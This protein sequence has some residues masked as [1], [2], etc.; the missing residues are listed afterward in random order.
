[1]PA[2]RLSMRKIKEVIRLKF[3]AGLGN[4]QIARSCGVNH[5][6]VADYLRRAK[7]AGLASWPL[8]V[9]LDETSLEVRLFPPGITRSN[10]PRSAPDWPHIHEELHGHKHVTLQLLW[11]EYK[12]PEP[13]GYQYSRFCELYQRWK[14]KLDL[15]LRQEHRAGEK[16]FVDYA[17]QT[18]P[19]TNPKTG[20]ITQASIFVAVLG[21]SNYTYAEASWKQDLACWIRSHVRVLEFLGASPAVLVPDNLKTGVRHPCRYEP[22]L[23]PTYQEMAAHYG[24]AVIPARVRKPRDKAKVEGG[25]LLVER[26]ILAA[27]RKRTF[28]GLADLN[29]AIGELLERLNQRRFRKLDGSRAEWFSKLDRPAL[30]PLPAEPYCFAEWKKARVNIDYHLEVDRHFYSVP[31][32]LVHRELDVRYTAM[33]VEVLHGGERVAS[34]ARSYKAGA[35]TTVEAH[36]PK[37]HQG[38]LEWTPERLVHWASTTGPSIAT[39]IDRILQSRTYPE[40]AFRS[41]LGILRLGK[42]YGSDRLEAAARRALKL[43]AC[44]YKSVKSILHTGLDRQAVLDLPPD[45]IPIQHAN[46]RGTDY[47]NSQEEP[48]C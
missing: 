41:C 18:V 15:V 43:D 2:E 39:L 14:S 31:F 34:H 27:L 16:L 10:R 45:R 32:A 21:A 11:E 23:N 40:Q 36:R 13:G 22:D 8:P 24:I 47:F 38:H 26:W 19:V 20:E 7:T 5:S 12:Q 44:S 35:F 25:V 3:E 1:M 4:R 29:H 42:T 46:I 33:T 48:S 17:G 30:R 28:F 37:S 6:T 9:E